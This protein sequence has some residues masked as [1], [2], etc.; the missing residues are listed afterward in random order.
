MMPMNKVLHLGNGRIVIWR[1]SAAGFKEDVIREGSY[2]TAE[3]ARDL[4]PAAEFDVDRVIA[5]TTNHQGSIVM[6]AKAATI[7][8]R[9]KLG[10]VKS[11]ASK[12]SKEKPSVKDAPTEPRPASVAR[13]IKK[14]FR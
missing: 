8:H 5:R 10:K 11:R 1:I 7:H 13:K 9:I 14:W 3:E 12:A 2:Q 4:S 6:G